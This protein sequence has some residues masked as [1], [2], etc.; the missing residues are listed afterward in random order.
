M[1]SHA[2]GPTGAASARDCTDDFQR[3]QDGDRVFQRHM[4]GRVFYPRAARQDEEFSIR[5]L[6]SLVGQPRSHPSNISFAAAA[7]SG[8]FRSISP[9][10][11]LPDTYTAGQGGSRGQPNKYERSH[12]IRYHTPHVATA[13]G[14]C[15]MGIGCVCRHLQETPCWRQPPHI[16]D[17]KRDDLLLS[18]G[19]PTSIPREGCVSAEGQ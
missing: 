16:Q 15:D 8:I 7:I 10:L 2:E 13:P 19:R 14:A 4:H 3:H 18:S 12:S 17:T 6:R 9:Y 1:L 5:G 11:P